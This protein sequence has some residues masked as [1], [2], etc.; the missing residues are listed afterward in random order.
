MLLSF[1][2]SREIL[3]LLGGAAAVAIGFAM[4]DLVASVVAGVMIM[5]D[6]PFQLGDRVSFGGQYGDVVSVGLRSVKIKTLDDNT[7]TVPNNMFLNEVSSSGNY[8]ALD[9][10]VVVDFHIGVDQDYKLAEQHIRE[11]TVTSRFIFLPKPIVVLVSQVFVGDYVAI[12]LRLKAYVL[13]TQYEK[14]F[15]TD[16]TLR[17]L[18]AFAEDGIQPPAVLHRNLDG[19]RADMSGASALS[20]QPV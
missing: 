14:N 15:E 2:I 10:Q 19:P 6:R 18:E 7:V 20:Q 13:D 11:A 8:G 16:V 4:K 3:A 9:M 17:V 5:V 1:E 12:R